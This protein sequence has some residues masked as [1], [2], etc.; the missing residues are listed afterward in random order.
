[1]PH[2]D[3]ASKSGLESS[4]DLWNSSSTAKQI[5]ALGQVEMDI[6]T[7]L[8]L[9]SSSM[10]LLAIP[11]PGEAA[12]APEAD[13]D[14]AAP[15]PGALTAKEAVATGEE[16]AELFVDRANQ[17]FET[18]DSIQ[19]N[20]RKALHHLRQEKISPSSIIAPPPDYVPPT[21]GIGPPRNSDA[22]AQPEQDEI[23]RQGLQETRVEKEAWLGIVASLEKLKAARERSSM[24]EPAPMDFE[25]AS[26]RTTRLRRVRCLDSQG[27]GHNTHPL[28]TCSK[29]F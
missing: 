11:R 15:I 23:Y 4:E 1:M 28:S 9:A 16:R 6:A 3:H 21:L 26:Y 5:K 12:E 19:Y 27:P 24:S 7:L 20:L 17:Y 10:K 14:A 29:D 8:Q 22:S 25:P 2:K 13:E 18:L